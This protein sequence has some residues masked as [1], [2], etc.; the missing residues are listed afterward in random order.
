MKININP[1]EAIS[2]ISDYILKLKYKNDYESK[3]L[4]LDKDTNTL[5]YNESAQD[6]FLHTFSE[7]EKII[8]KSTYSN[9][10]FI[11]ICWSVEDFKGQARDRYGDAWEY[12]LDETKFSNALKLME[13]NHD[14]NIGI[15][16]EVIDYYLDE[17]CKHDTPVMLIATLL[18]VDG[19][20]YKFNFDLV[21]NPESVEELIIEEEYDISEFGKNLN[22]IIDNINHSYDPEIDHTIVTLE[23]LRIELI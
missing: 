2:E 7:V 12:Y 8:E 9:N 21:I 17:Y 13:S 20:N 4:I 16:W 5:S 15:N 19:A 23:S 10:G 6:E 14:A 11:S 1:L 22:Y 3:C 18:Y